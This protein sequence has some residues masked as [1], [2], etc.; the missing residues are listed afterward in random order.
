MAKRKRVLAVGAHPDDIEF[1]VGGTLLKHKAA[2]DLI[3]I[4]TLTRGESGGADPAVR[5]RE[6]EEAARSL[7]ASYAI[8]DL[9]DTFVTEKAAID[10]VEEIYGVSAPDIAY[11]HSV[12]DTHQDHRAAGFGGRVALRGVPKLYAYQA[13]SATEEFA[14]ARFVN[15]DSH[16]GGK[17]KLIEFHKSQAGHRRYLEDEYVLA[18]ARYWGMRGGAC[19]HAEPLEVLHDRDAGADLF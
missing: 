11:I 14:P 16:T 1:G 18:T 6:A 19:L 7:G 9:P 15:I 13:P 5:Y 4:L 8:K 3:W 2:G 10:A 17:L 12:N